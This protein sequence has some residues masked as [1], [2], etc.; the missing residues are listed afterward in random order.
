M[1][2]HI[3]ERHVITNNCC[4]HAF[5]EDN[6]GNTWYQLLNVCLRLCYK[7]SKSNRQS[8]LTG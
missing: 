6:N 7:R 8:R 4:S 3:W 1:S 2:E 5:K